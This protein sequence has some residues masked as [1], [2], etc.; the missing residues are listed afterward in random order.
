MLAFFIFVFANAIMF[1]A[2]F[3]LVTYDV[4]VKSV[5]L[6]HIDC[7]YHFLELNYLGLNLNFLKL[8]QLLIHGD[9]ES[10]QGPTQNDL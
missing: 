2:I 5:R 4:C 3:I 9:M 8:A 7:L 10:N 6:K 1:F